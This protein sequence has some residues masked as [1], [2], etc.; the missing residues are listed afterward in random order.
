MSLPWVTPAASIDTL[1]AYKGDL[2]LLPRYPLTEDLSLLGEVG[3]MRWKAD[4]E[5]TNTN[6]HGTSPIF[7]A[8]LA[9]RVS[10]PVDLQVRYRHIDGVGS[11]KT[12]ESDSDN[13]SLDVVYYSLRLHSI[14]LGQQT[15]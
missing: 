5:A 7:G 6:D 13:V 3:V 1:S 4:N 8:G 14:G 10:D 15:Q 2:S 11:A 9:Y 12:G